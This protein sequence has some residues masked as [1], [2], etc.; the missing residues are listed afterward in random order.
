MHV[1]DKIVGEA[2]LLRTGPAFGLSATEALP[3]R[4][5]RPAD[6]MRSLRLR[7]R[8]AGE[9]AVV[10]VDLGQGPLVNAVRYEVRDLCAA[11]NENGPARVDEQYER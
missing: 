9:Q 6:L 7:L 3:R 8:S 4:L 1:G 11:A 5:Y 2:M 10:V